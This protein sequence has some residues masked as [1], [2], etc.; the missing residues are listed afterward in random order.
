M[1]VRFRCQA[2]HAHIAAPTRRGARPGAGFEYRLIAFLDAAV[3]TGRTAED[4]V[5]DRLAQAGDSAG[6]DLATVI[7]RT[8]RDEDRPLAA[9]L[10]AYPP[11]D[12]DG[13]HPSRTAQY[14]PLRDEGLAYARALR[15]AGGMCS[16]ATTTGSSTA[17]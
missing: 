13:D 12:F 7:A 3:E 17:S 8:F 4:A 10:P 2:H 15:K 14:D 16:Y 6:A 9:Q 1:D 5:R 11:T